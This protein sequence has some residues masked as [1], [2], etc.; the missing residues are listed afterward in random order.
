[1]WSPTPRLCPRSGSWSTKVTPSTDSTASILKVP[2]AILLLLYSAN[3]ELELLEL[4]ELLEL[5]LLEL[6]DRLELLDERLELLD[7]KLELLELLE[8]KELLELLLLLEEILLAE[9]L[10]ELE[11]ELDLEELELEE[12]ELELELLELAD[13]VNCIATPSAHFSKF[14]TPERFDSLV[15]KNSPSNSL[16]VVT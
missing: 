4:E 10:L 3:A 9:L 12:L 16:L 13:T 5:L 7:D 15:L 6:D 2:F 14:I 8:L 11:E 1:M